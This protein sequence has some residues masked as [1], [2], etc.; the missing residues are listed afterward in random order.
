MAKQS[1]KSIILR[2]F[3]IENNDPKF[4]KSPV[5]S[6][7]SSK[8]EE[9]AKAEDRRIQL[10]QDDPNEESDLISDFDISRK[11]LFIF[12]TMI[13][14]TASKGTPNLPDALFDQKTIPFSKLSKLELKEKFIYRSHFYFATNGSFLVVTLPSN[15]TITAFQAY[16]NEYLKSERGEHLFEFTPLIV[17]S[18]TTSISNIKSI[19]FK[20]AQVGIK[21]SASNSA[22]PGSNSGSSYRTKLMR[23]KEE[24]LKT[25]LADSPDLEKILEEGFISAELL[26]KFSSKKSD[27]AQKYLGAV[28]KPI[29]DTDNIEIKTAAGTI[30]GS[31]LQKTKAVDVSIT[32]SSMLSETELFQAMEGFLNELG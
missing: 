1:T 6:L 3:K 29:A 26:I 7:L 20:D 21:P 28:L 15:R 19:K 23:V 5:L 32:E 2:A 14:V 31:S 8:L 22:I 18:P 27:E 10:N 17:E 25:L 12:G 16:L 24:F 13:R 11:E 4:D 9:S 30:K